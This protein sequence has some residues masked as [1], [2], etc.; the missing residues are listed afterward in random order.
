MQ[1]GQVEVVDPDEKQEGTFYLPHHAVSKGKQGDIK[2][3]I[4][5]DRSS[6]ETGAPSLNDALEM[7]PNLLPELFITLLPFRLNPVAIIGDIHQAFFQLQLDEKDR[8]LT[9]IF[10]Y[11]VTRDDEVNYNTTDEVTCYRFTRLPFGINCSPFLL[12]ASVR[13]LANTQRIRFP[14]RQ[15]LLIAVHLWTIL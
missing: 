6:H 12:S 10:W 13:E 3:R 1:R 15:L 5:Y 8:D 7:G 4:V 2:W 9:R 11:R 14:R